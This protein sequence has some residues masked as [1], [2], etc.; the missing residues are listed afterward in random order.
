[1]SE[2]I[3][4]KENYLISIIS[5]HTLYIQIKDFMELEMEDIIEM[6]E[7][8][9]LQTKEE[10]LVNLIQFGNG[11]SAS[12]EAREYASSPEGNNITI[13]SALLVRN[14]AQ[15]LI[16]DYYMK[17]NNPIFPTKAFYKREKAEKWIKEILHTS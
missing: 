1:M 10:K 16:I 11:S 4:E 13:G 5:Q 15:Q 6:Q 12:R 14:M 9:V 3:L 7:W 8:V 2:N 17:F